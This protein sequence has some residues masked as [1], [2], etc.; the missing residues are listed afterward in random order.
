MYLE[1]I[2][3]F[4]VRGSTSTDSMIRSAKK[5]VVEPS[6]TVGL[7]IDSDAIQNVSSSTRISCGVHPARAHVSD[8]I[9]DSV[10]ELAHDTFVQLLLQVLQDY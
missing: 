1:C 7:G 9:C 3:A 2:Q 5:L 4:Q 6:A 8:C 10:R